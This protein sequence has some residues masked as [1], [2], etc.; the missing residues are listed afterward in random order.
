MHTRPS[1]V[2]ANFENWNGIWNVEIDSKGGGC[3]EHILLQN[4]VQ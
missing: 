4:L 2:K 1:S 3:G